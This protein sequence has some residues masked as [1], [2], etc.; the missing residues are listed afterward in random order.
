[1]AESLGVFDQR[2][3]NGT[4]E[5]VYVVPTSHTFIPK[6]MAITN[7]STAAATVSIWFAS[8]ADSNLNKNLVLKDKNVYASETVFL[9]TDIYL[10]AGY[11]II[12][13]SSAAS[14]LNFQLS[15]VDL[16]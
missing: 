2:I 10:Q 5:T 3:L 4:A 14:S 9:N 7:Y 8:T 11:K 15:G 16:Y 12:V 1:M 13:Q 6:T